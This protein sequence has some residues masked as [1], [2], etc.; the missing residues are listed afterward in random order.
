MFVSDEHLEKANQPIEV[1]FPNGFDAIHE[2]KFITKAYCY[3]RIYLIIK[4]H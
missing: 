1:N 3:M 2:N 4:V